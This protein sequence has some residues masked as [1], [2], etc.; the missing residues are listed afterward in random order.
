MPVGGGASHSTR[1]LDRRQL[2]MNIKMATVILRDSA[3]A[4]CCMRVRKSWQHYTSELGWHLRSRTIPMSRKRRQPWGP[5]M[6]R[7]LCDLFATQGDQR[8]DLGGTA[9]RDVAGDH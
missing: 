1:K 3:G 8:I 7:V 9:C 2:K 4:I 5:G 6:F